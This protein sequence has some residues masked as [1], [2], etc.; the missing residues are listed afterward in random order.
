[1][2]QKRVKNVLMVCSVVLGILTMPVQGAEMIVCAEEYEYDDLN[3][4]IKVTYDDGGTVEYVYDSNGNIIETI[5]SSDAS[6]SSSVEQE[7]DESVEVAGKPTG[8]NGAAL[9][10]K[11]TELTEP[12]E[13][14]APAEPVEP[15]EL[16]EPIVPAEP[17]APGK[18]EQSESVRKIV[19]AFSLLAGGFGT[20]YCIYRKLGK[21]RK[22]K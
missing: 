1:M 11:P 20:A 15:T 17:A 19:E 2:R 7:A 16:A 18:P 21:R 5:V 8:A 4:I 14:T 22:S 10:D 6:A 12:T 13:S 3:R 9:P